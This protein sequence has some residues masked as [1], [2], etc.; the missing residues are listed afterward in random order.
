MPIS[1]KFFIINWKENKTYEE[2]LSFFCEFLKLLNEVPFTDREII[3]CP[4]YPFLVPFKKELSLY[5]GNIPVI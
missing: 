4:S 3:F 1:N 5:K 2:G